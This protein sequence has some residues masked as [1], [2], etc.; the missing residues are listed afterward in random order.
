MS[1]S[2]WRM[3]VNGDDPHEYEDPL[4]DDEG[5]I[6]IKEGTI[7]FYLAGPM[8]GHD[9]FNFPA[10]DSA[11]EWLREDGYEVISPAELDREVGFDPAIDSDVDDDFLAGA[12]RRDVTA[13]TQ[14]DGVVLLPGWEGSTGTRFE[15]TVARAMGLPVLELVEADDPPCVWSWSH[16]EPLSAEGQELRLIAALEPLSTADDTGD[17][18]APWQVG[19]VHDPE[20]QRLLDEE[21]EIERRIMERPDDYLTDM[22]GEVR[23]TS[24]TGG[25]KGSKPARFDMIPPDVLWELAEHYGKGEAKYPSDPTTGEANWQK[26][27]AWHLSVAALERHLTAWLNGE[28]TDLETGS[29]HLI[30]VVWHAIALRWFQLHGRGTDDLQ[31]RRLS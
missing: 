3:S 19:G 7:H 29:S 1:D 25:E 27:Y 30:A 18:A 10:F 22:A 9:L 5:C 4:C 21:A 24:A 15:L 12:M 28:D 11:A 13:L 14:V 16:L 17:T 31:G 20:L 8:R 6:P 23:V 2:G 26:G